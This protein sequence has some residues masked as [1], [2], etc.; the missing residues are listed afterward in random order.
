MSIVSDLHTRYVNAC[1]QLEFMSDGIH[2]DFSRL[3][4]GE[5]GYLATYRGV[6]AGDPSIGD[7][8]T[9]FE[10]ALD[11]AYVTVEMLMGPCGYFV[12][13]ANALD[14]VLDGLR[15]RRDTLARMRQ[16]ELD[17]GVEYT[18]ADIPY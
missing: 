3:S 13:Q 18:Y 16:E 5:G 6:S 7:V 1:K 4:M 12:T 9:G 17:T 2:N 15:H 8:V 11:R 14:D 10:S